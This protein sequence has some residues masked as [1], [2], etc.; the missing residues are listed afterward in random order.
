M[1]DPF[2]APTQ[3]GD[4][5]VLVVDGDTLRRTEIADHLRNAGFF[6]VLEAASGDVAVAL[7]RAHPEV[8]L[9]VT[10][11]QLQGS[12]NGLQLAAWIRA[13]RQDVKVIVLTTYAPPLAAVAGIVHLV[14]FKPV[15][16]DEL[17][18]D[19]VDLLST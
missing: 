11:T 1:R 19:G 8:N 9:V 15:N 2:D 14:L 10:E 18:Q 16:G 7:L 4:R 13:N 5:H 3:R 17:V 6:Q 12:L